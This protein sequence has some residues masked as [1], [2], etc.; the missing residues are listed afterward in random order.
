MADNFVAWP[1]V[2]NDD[3]SLTVGTPF[4][5]EL[6]QAIRDSLADNLYSSTNPTIKA[7]TIIDEVKSARGSMASLDARLDVALNEDGTP[8]AVAGQ[9]TEAQVGYQLGHLNLIRNGGLDAWGNGGS[10]APDNFTLSGTGATIAQCGTSK[11]DTTNFG[12]GDYTAKITYGSA[13]A[14]LLQSVFSAA[15][16]TKWSRL[17]GK[18]VAI[19][20]RCKASVAN[21]A[22]FVADDGVTTT[23]GG[24]GGNGTYHTGGGS[25]EWLYCIH[26]ISAAATKLDVYLSVASSGSPYFGGLYAVIADTAVLD[27]TPKS[28]STPSQVLTGG[29]NKLVRTS[30]AIL[31]SITQQTKSANGD[32]FYSITIPGGTLSQDG[33]R[34]RITLWGVSGS[35]AQNFHVAPTFG[36]TTVTGVSSGTGVVMRIQQTIEIQRVTA[37]TQRLWIESAEYNS[38]GGTSVSRIFTGAPAETLANDITLAIKL[39]STGTKTV[40]L[41]GYVIEFLPA[42]A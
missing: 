23:R 39:V 9:A 22:S 7:K 15:E 8:K 31:S 2:S 4:S 26:A 1:S 12:T 38:G 28:E 36:A 24:Q 29:A 41:D 34:I 37:T 21:Q 5:A 17:K 10:A 33:D 42:T 6:I 16:M 3:G 27:W 32:T 20:V 14:K 11:A 40:T 18:S 25:D 30:G 13:E 35:E 19:G